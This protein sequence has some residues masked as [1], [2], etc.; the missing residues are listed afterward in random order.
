M[1]RGAAADPEFQ[2]NA[3]IPADDSGSLERS[4]GC[5][6]HAFDQL[7]TC[8]DPA[9]TAPTISIS[10]ACGARFL[11][12]VPMAATVLNRGGWA[13]YRV[14]RW[15]WLDWYG[16]TWVSY[17]PG[18]GHLITTAGGFMSRLWLVLVSGGNRDPA[19]LVPGAGGVLRLRRSGN[20][21]WLRIRQYRLGAACAVRG[22]ASVVG[23]RLLWTARGCHRQ[24]E[25]RQHVPQSARVAGG[26]SGMGTADFR[27]GRFNS[28]GRVSTDQVRS[29]GRCAG[30]CR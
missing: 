18:A 10:T 24:C 11:R 21:D 7:S 5:R 17:D 20:R 13:R 16:W 25:Y 23:P 12:M 1:A 26:I 8:I 15:V 30:K 19:L 27:A 29:A 6:A 14:G 2:I 9:C 22:A 4:P 3:A 28:I